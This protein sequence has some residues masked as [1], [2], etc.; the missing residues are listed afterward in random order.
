M[1]QRRGR[2]DTAQFLA[3]S[4]AEINRL[5]QLPDV[6]VV[7][8]DLVDHGAPAEYG[9]LRALLAPLRMPV[10]VIPGNHDA[11]ESLRQAFGADGY[12]PAEGFLQFAIEDFPV[13]R[14]GC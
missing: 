6:V 8:A 3:R 2:L 9:H 7:T 10:F 12:L 14:S 5:A 1:P 4:V 11:R 13:R